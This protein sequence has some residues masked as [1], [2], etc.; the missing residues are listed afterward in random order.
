MYH[1]K[2]ARA[3]TRI[4]AV[5]RG[6]DVRDFLEH[7]AAQ[8]LNRLHPLHAH[9]KHMRQCGNCFTNELY[10]YNLRKSTRVISEYIFE[11][12]AVYSLRCLY[13]AAFDPRR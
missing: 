7:P 11:S 5:W 10:V 9:T 8:V 3:A 1:Y 6:R 13:L 4:Q 12:T 2:R